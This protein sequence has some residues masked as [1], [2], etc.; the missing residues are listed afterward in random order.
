MIENSPT[1]DG[2]ID[3][4]RIEHAVRE[5]LTAVGQDPEGE[6][7]LET[8]RRVAEAYSELFQGLAKDPLRHLDVTFNEDYR[9]M[10]VIRDTPFHSVCAHHLLPFFGKAHVGYLPTGRVIGL[11]KL[12]RVVEDYA[13]RP[14]LQERLTAQVADALHRGLESE[15]SMVVIEAHHLCM[16]IRGVQKQ[17]ATTATRAVRGEFEEDAERRREAMSLIMNNTEETDYP[18]LP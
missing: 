9:E 14:Q 10:I 16:A 18:L 17:G 2:A 7:V 4:L 15:G 12:A 1:T 11:S 6:D 13:K 3:K 8:P 5:I